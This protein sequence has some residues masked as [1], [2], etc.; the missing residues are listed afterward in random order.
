VLTHLGFDRATN[1]LLGVIFLLFV[2]TGVSSNGVLKS[3]YR[4]DVDDDNLPETFIYSLI[5][6]KPY[7]AGILIQSANG[8]ALW[9]HSWSMQPDDLTTLME[10]EGRENEADWVKRFFENRNFSAGTY[11]KT[12]LTARDITDEYI[13][14]W[15]KEL[16][17]S[18][19][20]LKSYILTQPVNHTFHYRAEWRE[21]FYALVYVPE[22]EKFVQYTGY[23][24]E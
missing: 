21:D 11:N 3:E 7:E 19:D 18:P 23:G 9:E 15:A 8:V 6:G 16:K 24:E 1:K 12:K 5:P 17:V 4:A 10:E 14:F 13:G 20:R 2:A 22:L